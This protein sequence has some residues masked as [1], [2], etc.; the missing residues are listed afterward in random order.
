MF[1]P[2]QAII[3]EKVKKKWSLNVTIKANAL[4]QLAY[5]W[6]KCVLMH[7]QNLY[8]LSQ[9][10]QSNVLFFARS[11]MIEWDVVILDNNLKVSSGKLHII[12]LGLIK[13]D[14]KG[15][16]IIQNLY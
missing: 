14:D 2:D 1:L 8:E 9:Y 11:T 12:L 13:P 16:M 10:S 4:S 15:T 5:Y 6:S 7:C 3:R